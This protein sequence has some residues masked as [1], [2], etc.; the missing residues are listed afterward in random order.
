[1]IIV[2]AVCNIL[3]KVSSKHSYSSVKRDQIGLASISHDLSLF[4]CFLMLIES[5]MSLIKE[6]CNHRCKSKGVGY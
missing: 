1:M 4:L 2:S 6:D 5:K 3:T